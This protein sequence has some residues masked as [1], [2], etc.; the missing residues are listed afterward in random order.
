MAELATIA[1]PYA[2][3]LFR[4]AEA[5]DIAAWS[6]LVQE[7]AQVARLPDV[8]SVASSPKVTR[9]QVVELL[10]ATQKSPLAAS[11]EAKNFVQM[12]VDNHRIALLPEIATQFDELKNARE[13]AADAT[14]V[15]AYPLNGTELE[16]LV[17]GLERKFKRKL[18]PTVQVDSSLIGG[19]RVT[20]GDEV[21]D[22]SVRARL[23]SM[24][25]ALAA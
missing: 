7:L 12:L 14:I 17:S 16:G 6:S 18:K 8:L 22:T 9:A 23:A 1:R 15:S 13:G 3:A 11:A 24:Q 4:V 25:A 19:V 20:V 5:G 2:E 21:L 10:L